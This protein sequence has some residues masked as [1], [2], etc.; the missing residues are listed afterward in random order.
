MKLSTQQ[1]LKI[2]AF[3]KQ[4]GVNYVDVQ[5]EVLDH[6]AS[7]IEHKMTEN[8]NLEFETAL[9]QTHAS[10]G[11]FGLSTIAD[12]IAEGLDRK[13]RKIFWKHF[14]SFFG[15]YLPFTL[16]GGVLFYKIQTLFSNLDDLLFVFLVALIVLFLLIV[17]FHWKNKQYNKILAFK[18][19]ILYLNF[20]GSF[21][22][23]FS[24]VIRSNFTATLLMLNLNYLLLSVV[25]VIFCMYMLSA[26]KTCKVGLADSQKLM[27][28]YTF[29]KL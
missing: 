25:L 26:Y 4:K 12:A 27:Q 22:T 20:L 9:Q 16:L 3:V 23:I 10:F 11:I 29:T 14:S 6:M 5:M 13:Y 18:T 17:F 8:E 24:L 1:L 2:E 19:S 15:K 28:K 7:A 21:L